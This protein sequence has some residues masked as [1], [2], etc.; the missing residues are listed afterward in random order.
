VRNLAEID[1]RKGFSDTEVCKQ[2][3]IYGDFSLLLGSYKDA[4]EY[5]SRIET[6][7]PKTDIKDSKWLAGCLECLVAVQYLILKRKL[8]FNPDKYSQE[9][10]ESALSKVQKSLRIYGPELQSY[11]KAASCFVK[12]SH[13]FKVMNMQSHFIKMLQENLSIIMHPRA[14]AANKVATADYAAQFGCYRTSAMLLYDAHEQYKQFQVQGGGT[15]AINHF[16]RCEIIHM[17]MQV[18][19]K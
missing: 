19:G 10:R 1:K 17:I 15:A 4:I 5:F 11:S 13:F 14:S 9:K 7:F 2:L 6:I 16:H 8:N 18:L 12:Y 3:K